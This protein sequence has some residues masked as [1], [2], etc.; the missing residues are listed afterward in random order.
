MLYTSSTDLQ[1]GANLLMILFVNG[2]KYFVVPIPYTA[3]RLFFL[4]SLEVSEKKM[5]FLGYGIVVSTINN[6]I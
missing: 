6:H 5:K 2:F 4:L 3:D 1:Y